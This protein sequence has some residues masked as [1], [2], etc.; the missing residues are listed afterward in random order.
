METPELTCSFYMLI[1]SRRVTN[2]DYARSRALQL[3]DNL[4]GTEVRAVDKV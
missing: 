1:Y 4:L 2:T 3:L